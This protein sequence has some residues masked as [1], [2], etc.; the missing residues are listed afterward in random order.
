VTKKILHVIFP[1][2]ERRR[3][4]F[5][6]LSKLKGALALPPRVSVESLK[7]LKKI[8]VQTKANPRQSSNQ[9]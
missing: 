6:L 7:V 9:P 1:I 5:C 3:F 8:Q 2:S 4:V